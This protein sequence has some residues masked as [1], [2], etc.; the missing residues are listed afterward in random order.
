MPGVTPV[1][2]QRLKGNILIFG[3]LA[4]FSIAVYGYSM[5]KMAGEDFKEYNDFGIKKDDV[6]LTKMKRKPRS[7][8]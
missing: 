4:A 5:W 7:N 1:H 3:S 6:D 2:R 8:E